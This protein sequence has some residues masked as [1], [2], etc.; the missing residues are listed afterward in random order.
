MQVWGWPGFPAKAN[1]WG[2][3]DKQ[4]NPSRDHEG[5][6]LP[7]SHQVICLHRMWMQDYTLGNIESHTLNLALRSRGS[8]PSIVEELYLSVVKPPRFYHEPYRLMLA[9]TYTDV[10]L[11]S[12]TTYKAAGWQDWGVSESDGW[13]DQP[14]R[15]LRCWVKRLQPHGTWYPPVMRLVG[16]DEVRQGRRQR[17]RL[18]LSQGS[19]VQV[20][21]EAKLNG[22]QLTFF[23]GAGRFESEGSIEE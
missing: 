5:N 16:E 20:Q 6:S 11:H 8:R 4:G 23:S 1:L 17:P 3:L 7:T 15:K 10:A 13:R 19:L 22:Q 2:P 9:V 12:G 14:G 21:G 18:M